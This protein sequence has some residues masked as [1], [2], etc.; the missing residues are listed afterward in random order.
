M[1]PTIHKAVLTA[2]TT[3]A[4]FALS[5]GQALASHVSCGDTIT[6]DTKLNSDLVNCPGDGVV[7]G[8]DN[9]TLDLNGHTIDGDVASTTGLGVANGKCTSLGCVQGYDGVTIEHGTVKEFGTG[10]AGVF[11]ARRARLP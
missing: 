9:I 11:R 1:R 6:Q 7:I 8:A 10:V 2:A 5:G 4:L 3:M